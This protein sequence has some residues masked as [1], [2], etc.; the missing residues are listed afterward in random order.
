MGKDVIYARGRHLWERRHLCAGTSSMGKT[1]SMRE[2]VIY[3][4]VI[5]ARGRHLWG[6]TSS[7]RAHVI[8]GAAREGK[9]RNING[10]RIDDRSRRSWRPRSVGRNRQRD[11]RLIKNKHCIRP[12][13]FFAKAACPDEGGDG[14]VVP[15]FR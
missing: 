10:L 11:W 8:Y 3:G 7:K 13:I 15:H 5:C 2:D 1:S 4:D 9:N 12:P 6:K 14:A